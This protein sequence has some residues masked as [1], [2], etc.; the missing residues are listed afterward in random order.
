MKA[1]VAVLLLALVCTSCSGPEIDR[2]DVER[3]L[4]TLAADDMEGRATFSPGIERAQQFIRD[5]FDAI[6]LEQLEGL[7][8]YV[9]Q[10]YARSMSPEDVKVVLNGRVI[11]M[12]RVIARV[13][14]ESITWT[15][16]GDVNVQ[17][18]GRDGDLRTAIFSALR[19]DGNNLVV[20]HDSHADTFGRYR[21]YLSR[22]SYSLDPTEGA[23]TVL[24]L[25]SEARVRSFEVRITSAQEQHALA[26]VVGVIPGRRSD[27]IVLFTA[28]HDH[29]GISEAIDGDSIMNGANDDASGTAAV[30]ALAKYFKA[31]PKPERTLIFATFTGEEMGGFGSEYLSKQLDPDQIVAMFNIEMI[32][33]GGKDGPNAAWITG[34][35]ES[36]F[37]EILARAV[38][39]TEFSFSAD[40]F[41]DENLF[42]RSD[43]A[44]FARLG[45]P[46]HT[47]STTPIDV[48]EDYHQ[49]SD[50]LETIDLD[51]M[52]AVIKAIATAAMPIIS[53]EATPTRIDASSLN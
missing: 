26:N 27:E 40:P 35:E 53:G 8:D 47:V 43:N 41:P 37:G 17:V 12:D 4:S 32:G 24:V 38:E 28:H 34:F 2:A 13:S 44:I 15:S 48:D 3:V 16:P 11:Q 19:R 6:G 39:G 21:R 5:E 30:I 36:D 23:N 45:V 9:Q 29:V 10:F 31:S 50:E 49:V 18:V 51:H 25:S 46:A 1:V 7:D 22:P 42:Y 20:I 33:K 52:T 14:N